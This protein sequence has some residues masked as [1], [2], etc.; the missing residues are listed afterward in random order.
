MA[1]AK[2]LA[3]ASSIGKHIFRSPCITYGMRIEVFVLPRFAIEQQR[4]HLVTT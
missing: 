1:L 4:K 3:D 2:R